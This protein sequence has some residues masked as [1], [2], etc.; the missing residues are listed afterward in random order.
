MKNKY[1]IL[2]IFIFILSLASCNKKTIQ[3]NHV[4]DFL[5]ATCL[6][7]SICKECDEE[8]GNS[9]GHDFEKVESVSST[10][11]FDGYE[12]YKCTRCNYA[13]TET[14][15]SKGH[16]L[17]EIELLPTCT[18]KGMYTTKC[19]NCDYQVDHDIP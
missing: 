13:K 7:A 5:D 4:H 1:L 18:E 8:I 12:F 10:C 17:T 6:E 3:E 11:L 9:L 15:E 14:V 2:L 16:D 19:I